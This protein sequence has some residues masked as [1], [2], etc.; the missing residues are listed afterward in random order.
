MDKIKNLVNLHKDKLNFALLGCAIVAAINCLERPDYNIFVYLYMYY[1]WFMMND[2]KVKKIL[3]FF[4][5]K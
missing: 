5:I 1:V 4:I 2:M 3:N